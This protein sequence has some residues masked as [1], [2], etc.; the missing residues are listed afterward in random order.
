MAREP[1]E[2][3]RDRDNREDSE[4]VDKLVHIN[5]VAKVVK[6]GRRFGFAALVVVGDQKGRVGFGHG[7]A[8]EV[9]EAIRKATEAAKRGLIRVPLREGRTLH[10]DVDGRHGAGKVVLRAAPAGT[11]IIAGG[12]M[13]AV[14]ETLGVHDVVAKSLG[15]SN[16]Y[17]MV[18]ATFAALKHEDSP[19]SVAA[20]RGLKVSTLQSRRRDV[21]ADAVAEG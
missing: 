1:R 3:R 16:P 7:K 8:R 14:F 15:S 6:G 18:R 21:D 5:R 9:P 13:R 20:R 19:R 2:N 17:N 12:P 4:F 10:H 11:G